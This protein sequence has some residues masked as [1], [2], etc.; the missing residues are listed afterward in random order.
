MRILCVISASD[1]FG[2]V[3][4]FSQDLRQAMKSI[5]HQTHLELYDGASD[6]RAWAHVQI[7]TIDPDLVFLLNVWNV[8][9]ISALYSLK[10][11]VRKVADH[12]PTCLRVSRVLLGRPCAKR[13]NLGCYLCG[14]G[15]SRPHPG[16]LL[17]QVNSLWHKRAE[18]NGVRLSDAILVDTQY[19]KSML[20][21]NGIQSDVIHV[22]PDHTR[23]PNPAL[24]SSPKEGHIL[25]VGRLHRHKGLGVLLQAL[26]RVRASWFLTIVGVGEDYDRLVALTRELGLEDRVQFEGWVDDLQPY[27]VRSSVVIVPSVWPEPFG[28]VGIEAMA[29]ARPTIAFDVGGISE[30]LEPNISGLLLPHI[31]VESLAIAIDQ[32]LADPER[33]AMMGSAGRNLVMERFDIHAYPHKILPVL[34][35]A[36]IAFVSRAGRPQGSGQSWL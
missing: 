36:R 3:K 33:A 26:S 30:W 2:G 4:E 29:H 28:R 32:L 24:L 19:M 13:L 17:P 25:F 15:F 8:E 23:L 27:F 5:G 22:L 10:P 35:A 12:R 1:F 20:T 34:E 31:S 6:I 11:I 9:L 16:T 21:R 7:Q 18:L 14:C